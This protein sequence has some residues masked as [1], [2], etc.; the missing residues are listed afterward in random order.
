[1]SNKAI[2]FVLIFLAAGCAETSFTRISSLNIG[3]SVPKR[4]RGSDGYIMSHSGQFSPSY[5]L[6]WGGVRYVVGVQ[7]KSNRTINFVITFSE[8]FRTPEGAFVGMEYKELKNLSSDSVATESGW[9]HFVELPSGWAARF[10]SGAS[11]TSEPV[12]G[13]SKV[14]AFFKR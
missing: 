8:K 6:N 12:E 5:E 14:G 9:G 1:M 3:D 10:C 13:S 11:C 7:S 2:F 4:Y